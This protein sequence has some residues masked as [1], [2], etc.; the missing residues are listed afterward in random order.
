ME[1]I[2][3]I[4]IA[5]GLGWLLWPRRTNRE[6]RIRSSNQDEH[7]TGGLPAEH[8]R[9][10]MRFVN[11]RHAELKVEQRAKDRWLERYGRTEVA[12]LDTL[13]GVAFEEF[14]EGLFRSHGYEAR[15][16]PQN[17]DFGADLILTK[18]SERIAVQA[19]R[20]AGS[21]GVSAVQEALSGL[22]YYQCDQAWLVSTGSF[23]RNAMELAKKSRVRLIGRMEIG[24]MLTTSQT[25][26][27]RK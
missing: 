22:S 21:V 12:K 23:T 7:A 27:K 14:L 11:S 1:L 25:Q 19:K 17:S 2:F 13:D 24:Q 3:I 18:G 8:M 26:A 5:V 4:A 9:H 15:R 20:Y 16:T 10:A 6:D